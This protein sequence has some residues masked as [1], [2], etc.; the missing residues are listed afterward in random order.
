M[1]SASTSLGLLFLWR[2]L[3]FGLLRL[4]L[5]CCC[6]EPRL[7]PLIELSFGLL[8]GKSTFIVEALSL[9]F[10]NDECVVEGAIVERSGEGEGASGI[11]DDELGNL[12]ERLLER[13]AHL[14]EDMR[15]EGGLVA[16][17]VGTRHV[18]RNQAG[19]VR[20]NQQTFAWDEGS[21]RAE[22]LSTVV[23]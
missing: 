6:L 20:S 17:R 11:G 23:S 4:P 3:P 9:L 10:D 8:A 21:E 5:R 12:L 15:K 1:G 19:R 13:V 14:H 18:E 2:S 16:P 7:P 22:M